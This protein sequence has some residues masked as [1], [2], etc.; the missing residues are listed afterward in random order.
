MSEYHA[1][2]SKIYLW[3]ESEGLDAA[4]VNSDPDVRYLTGMPSDSIL[5]LMRSGKS[6]LLPWDANLADARADADEIIPY[7]EYDR[8]LNNALKAILTDSSRG[9]VSKVEIPGNTAYPAF[10][11]LVDELAGI[12]VICRDDG[13]IDRIQK[14]RSVKDAYELERLERAATITNDILDLLETELNAGGLSTEVDVALFLERESRARGG[15]GTGFDTIVAGATRSYGI[16]AFPT[17]TGASFAGRGTG[18]IDFGVLYDGYTSDVT[19]TVVFGKPTDVQSEMLELVQRAYDE[20]IER[21]VVGADA[22]EIAR[23]VDSIF[24]SSGYEMPHSLGHGVGLEVHEAPSLRSKSTE[25]SP[26]NPGMVFTIEP[27]RYHPIEG[28]V[29]LENDVLLTDSD[30]RIITKSRIVYLPDPA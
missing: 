25:P 26:L 16:H 23:H 28:G 12:E 15:D 18:I 1:R 30:A 19:V 13:L 27:G 21:A 6:I 22:G 10:S 7:T 8:N 24:E 20:A 9:A 29:R 17:Y 4:Y 2:R 5:I 14:M 11:K 3:L